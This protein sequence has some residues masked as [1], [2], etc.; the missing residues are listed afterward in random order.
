MINLNNVNSIFSLVAK[1]LLKFIS[2]EKSAVG[3]SWWNLIISKY[4]YGSLIPTT[5]V[6]FGV[7]EPAA[8]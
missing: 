2:I 4:V 3:L 7:S 8:K 1:L 5:C 6:L